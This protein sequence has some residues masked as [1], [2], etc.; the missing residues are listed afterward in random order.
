M[1]LKR[2]HIYN[3][4]NRINILKFFKSN[5]FLGKFEKLSEVSINFGC[6]GYSKTILGLLFSIHK[7]INRD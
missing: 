4:K 2:K 6:Q 3:K 1:L 7:N 5:K